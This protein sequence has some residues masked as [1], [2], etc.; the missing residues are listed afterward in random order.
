LSPST[1]FSTT[2]RAYHRRS[3]HDLPKRGVDDSPCLL[4]GLVVVGAILRLEKACPGGFVGLHKA[5]GAVRMHWRAHRWRRP[6][7]WDA[8]QRVLIIWGTRR[9]SSR[10][11]ASRFMFKK[12]FEDS[13]WLC[14]ARPVIADLEKDRSNLASASPDRQGLR[15][16]AV[17]PHCVHGGANQVHENLLDLDA[18]G[19]RYW[20]QRK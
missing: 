3:F 13:F 4:E 5:E 20:Q 6:A 18:V 12:K 11:A 2:M 16:I 19:G 1:S 17:R 9:R 14:K 7:N 15:F 8:A 10:T